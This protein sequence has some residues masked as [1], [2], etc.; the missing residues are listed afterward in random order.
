MLKIKPAEVP[1]EK[2]K[3]SFKLPQPTIETLA[4][5]LAA[6]KKIYGVE[7]DRDFVVDQILTSFFASDKEFAAFVKNGAEFPGKKVPA[8]V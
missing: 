1:P 5:Y 2:A 3:I 4:A 8:T 6:F 7:P